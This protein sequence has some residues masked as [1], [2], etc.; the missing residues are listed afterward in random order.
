M[1]EFY[2]K[3]KGTSSFDLFKRLNQIDPNTPEGMF[4]IASF[5]RGGVYSE[6]DKTEKVKPEGGE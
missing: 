5:E 4:C 3:E 6:T 2:R 1:Y